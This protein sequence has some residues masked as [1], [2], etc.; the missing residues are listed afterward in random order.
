MIAAGGN[1]AIARFALGFAALV[2]GA[3]AVQ[4][5]KWLEVGA[6]RHPREQPNPYF[7]LPRLMGAFLFLCGLALIGWSAWSLLM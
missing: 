5:S 6:P 2:L 3:L 1:V 7:E 4:Y